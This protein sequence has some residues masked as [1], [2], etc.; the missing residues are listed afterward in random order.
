MS[1][2]AGATPRVSIGL[3]VHNGERYVHLAIEAVLA[4][5]I[6][7]FELIISDN[8]STDCTERLCREYAARDARIRYLRRPANVGVTRNFNEVVS[9]AR[10]PYFKWASAD[11]L[12][13]P[14][15]LERCVEV[16]DRDRSVVLVHSKTRFIDADGHVTGEDEG[17]HL[18]EERPSDRLVSLWKQLHFCDA[19][20]GVMRTAALRR[21][22]LFGSFVGSDVCFLAELS[23]Y[24]KFFEVPEYLL[25]RRLHR[26]AASSLTPEQLLDHYGIS[27]GKL[28]LYYWRHLCEDGRS[29]LRAPIGAAEKARALRRLVQR[30][31]WERAALT[32]ELGFLARHLTGRPYRT[33]G[34]MPRFSRRDP[35]S[36]R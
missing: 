33:L 6:P 26:Q 12:I 22:P 19:Q 11:D 17:P 7:D 24:G 13:A 25:F 1:A 16:L 20:Y 23:L 8:A 29:I 28:V 21:T 2:G 9:E 3:P 31:V 10:A 15:L 14:T 4:Q 5:T 30:G 18:M 35:G 36:V 27:P 32:E 34:S